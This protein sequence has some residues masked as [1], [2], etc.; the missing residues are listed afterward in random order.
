MD[1]LSLWHVVVL[2][3]LSTVLPLVVLGLLY[4]HRILRGVYAWLGIPMVVFIGNR[5]RDFFNFGRDVEEVAN[6]LGAATLIVFVVLDMKYHWLKPSPIKIKPRE[7][8]WIEQMRSN[9][10]G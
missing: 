8:R 10:R 5:I 9:T 2:I 6:Y 1:M 7:S 4:Y 3:F